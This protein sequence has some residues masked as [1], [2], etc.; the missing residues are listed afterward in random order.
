MLNLRAAF[1]YFVDAHPCGHIYLTGPVYSKGRKVWAIKGLPKAQTL[2][3]ELARPTAL[4]ILA[5]G[6]SGLGISPAEAAI[7][8][9]MA[10]SGLRVH[11]RMEYLVAFAFT[12]LSCSVPWCHQSTLVAAI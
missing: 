1:D 10:T 11:K 6:A 8:A 7:Y 2:P 5:A 3:L 9:R 12:I 4:T